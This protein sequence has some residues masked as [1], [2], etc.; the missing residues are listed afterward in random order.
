MLSVITSIAVLAGVLAL[1]LVG[2]AVSY[3][4]LRRRAG[5]AESWAGTSLVRHTRGPAQLIVPLTA[6][7]MVAPYVPLPQAARSL[8]THALGIAL[9]LSTAWLVLRLRY[10]LEDVLLMRY[11]LGARDNLRAR[12]MHT[13]VEILR[14]ITVVVL[15]VVSL[16][17][18]LLSVP[19]VRA[20]GA[21]ILASAGVA[22]LIAGVAARP[23]AANL[24]AGIQLA[25]TQPI[26]VDDVVVVDGHWGRV[27]HI[28]LTYVVVREWDLRRLVL[29]IAYFTQNPFENWTRSTADI[30][31]WVHLELDY[32]VPVDVVRRRLHEILA[33]SPGWDGK[34]WSLQVTN[35]GVQTVQLRPLM[36]S[37]DSSASWDLQCEVR[38]KMLAFLQREYGQAVP[39]VRAEVETRSVREPVGAAG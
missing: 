39:R 7:E 28:A 1:G 38:E 36:S 20:A 4:V 18:V 10:V 27:E 22:G 32:T 8:L 14:R 23:L 9:V 34:V 11:R 5:N 29:P 26:R 21:G 17:L 35:L 30:L 3:F 13:Q 24:A 12:Q 33:E 15:A 2:H 19:E 6:A 16:A 25:L 37:P 31:G